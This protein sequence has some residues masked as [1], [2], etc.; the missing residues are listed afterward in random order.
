MHC[1]AM[2]SVAQKF[3]YITTKIFILIFEVCYLKTPSDAKITQ[4]Q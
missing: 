2:K 3:I 4:Y 1:K